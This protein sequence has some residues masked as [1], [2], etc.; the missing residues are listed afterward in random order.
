M[1]TSRM[2][3]LL[4]GQV[5]MSSLLDGRMTSAISHVAMENSHEG[6]KTPRIAQSQR[7]LF[8]NLCVLVPLWQEKGYMGNCWY[9]ITQS[10][11]SLDM[12]RGEVL[13]NGMF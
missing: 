11:L 1:L 8:V 4:Y 2:Q 12:K 10:V 13:M 3:M 9:D 5:L 6:S 7:F